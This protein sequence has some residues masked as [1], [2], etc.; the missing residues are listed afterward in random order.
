MGGISD[1]KKILKNTIFLYL[2][3]FVIMGIGLY[4]SREILSALGVQDFGI[5]NI[6]GGVVLVFSFITSSLRN[7]TQRFISFELGKENINKVRNIY[8]ISI[9]C[10]ILILFVIL[11]LAESIGLCILHT[12]INIPVE[13]SGVVDIVYQLSILTFCF[14]ILQVPFQSTVISY[15][16]MSFYAY[17]SIVEVFLKLFIV[18]LLYLAPYDKLIEYSVL[19]TFVSF[20]IL[21]IYY[22]YCTYK[23][24]LGHYNKTRNHTI[25]IDILKFSSF[26]MING[27]ASVLSI[28]GGNILINMFS[29][30]V[31]NAAAGIANQVSSQIY[32][33]VSNFQSAFQPQIVKLYAAND[34][35]SLDKLITRTSLASYYL[36]LLISVPIF[37]ETQYILELWL[38]EVPSY[39]SIF[40]K[41]LIIYFLI[42]AIQAPLWMLIYGTGNIKGYTIWSSF[43][44]FL[45]IPITWLL[46]KLGYPPYVFFISRATMNFFCSIYRIYDVKRLI[47]YDILI[48]LKNVCLR[49]SLI[50]LLIGS[51]IIVS[52]NLFFQGRSNLLNICL[53]LGFTLLCISLL[54][55]NSADKKIIL[56]LILT[57]IKR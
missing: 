12:F 18:L 35:V 41:W 29:G 38:V 28:Q 24:K 20:L 50:T 43:F 39:S 22:Y 37:C 2:R 15:E 48:Y 49:A 44:I 4:T 46:L 51:Y 13:R 27:S 47:N 45:N 32:A 36:I 8:N 42:D 3:M 5:Y 56:N 1:N 11:L 33:F 55:F 57:K 16:K 6:V 25:F 26:S 17:L 31:A 19:M 10:H 54:G 52:D 23:L 21:C 34:F 14:N 9:E 40:C 30:V 7:S 53:S